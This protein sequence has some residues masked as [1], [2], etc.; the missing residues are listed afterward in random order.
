FEQPDQKVSVELIRTARVDDVNREH[1]GAAGRAIES[2]C[3]VLNV[4]IDVLV[5]LKGDPETAAGRQALKWVDRVV[6]HLLTAAETSIKVQP[7]Q[8]L[9]VSERVDSFSE[10]EPAPQPGLVAP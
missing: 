7:S 10:V 6:E 1:A 8:D 2:Y 4:L 3:V 5:R 9:A